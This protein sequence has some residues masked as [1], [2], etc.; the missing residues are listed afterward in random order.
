MIDDIKI[1]FLC[2]L[3]FKEKVNLID[4]NLGDFLMIEEF[5]RKIKS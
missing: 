5:L 1:E 3:Y 2:I 4:D